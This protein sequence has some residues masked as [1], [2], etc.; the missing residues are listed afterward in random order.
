MI[1]DKVDKT[2]FM[3]VVCSRILVEL[4]E[5]ICV[6]LMSV[7]SLITEAYMQFLKGTLCY[8]HRL[9]LPIHLKVYTGLKKFYVYFNKLFSIATQYQTTDSLEIKGK[10]IPVTNRG[11]P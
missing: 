2:V 5:I 8:E 6:G 3:R 1:I 10:A 9:L 7:Q 11:G 4:G